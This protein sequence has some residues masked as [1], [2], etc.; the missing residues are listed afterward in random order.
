MKTV[1]FHENE[2]TIAYELD[3]IDPVNYPSA[4]ENFDFT[5]GISVRH[6]KDSPNRKIGNSVAE[7]R[8]SS[9]ELTVSSVTLGH[10]GNIML[11]ATDSDK[12]IKFF[13]EKKRNNR[14]FYL[15]GI[16]CLK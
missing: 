4:G 7:G 1:F 6:P 8:K 14:N 9:M 13:F 10:E 11:W 12:K 16:N 3:F 2:L 15:G 5:F